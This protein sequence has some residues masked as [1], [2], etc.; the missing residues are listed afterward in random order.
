MLLCVSRGQRL[1]G[2]EGGLQHDPSSTNPF[3]HRPVSALGGKKTGGDALVELDHPSN[4]P[5]GVDRPVWDRL[6]HAR[7]RKFESELKVR[8]FIYKNLHRC[9]FEFGNHFECTVT[10]NLTLP[11]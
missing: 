7:R 10:V 5:E 11:G 1:K 9:V 4:I 2:V 3:A 6:V 8:E